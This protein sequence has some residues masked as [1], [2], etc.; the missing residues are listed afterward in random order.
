[1]ILPDNGVNLINFA[2]D[3]TVVGVVINH[4]QIGR[5]YV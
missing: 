2:L 3:P 5:D 1:M 4:I